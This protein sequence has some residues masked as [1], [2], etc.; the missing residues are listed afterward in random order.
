MAGKISY[1]NLQV[2]LR[3]KEQVIISFDR[4]QSKML[5]KNDYCLSKFLI[6]T[7][8]RIWGLPYKIR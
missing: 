5:I 2:S 6:F 4:K 8:V 7:T 1:G 3:Q